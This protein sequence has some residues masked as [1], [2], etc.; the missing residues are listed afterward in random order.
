MALRP[1]GGNTSIYPSGFVV[2]MAVVCVANQKLLINTNIYHVVGVGLI[3][4]SVA[5][6]FAVVAIENTFDFD[7]TKGV[8]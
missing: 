2:Y 8:F 5:S 7:A 1:N 4:F 6:Y 3:I